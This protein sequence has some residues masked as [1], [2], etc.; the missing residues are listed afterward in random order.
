MFG[1]EDI[2]TASV[3]KDI[4]DRSNLLYTLVALGAE[5]V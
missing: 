4:T 1:V 3:V 2:L 5:C